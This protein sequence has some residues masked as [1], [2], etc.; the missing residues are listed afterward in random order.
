MC[1]YADEFLIKIS[2]NRHYCFQV[3]MADDDDWGITPDY[4]NIMTETEQR[5]G[6]KAVPGRVG[7]IEYVGLQFMHAAVHSLF[8]I[9]SYN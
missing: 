7:Y 5:F 8:V 2:N 4:K 1:L 3:K 6:S 9:H